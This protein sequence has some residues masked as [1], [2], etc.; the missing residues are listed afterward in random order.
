M[1]AIADLGITVSVPSNWHGEILRLHDGVSDSGPILHVAN[2]P[3][4]LGDTSGYATQT[5]Q[6]M[7]VTD[8]ILCVLNLPS[9]PHLLRADGVE[10]VGHSRRWS[11]AG[12]SETPFNAVNTSQSSL[13]KAIRVG[14]RVFDVIAFFGT[15]SPEPTLRKEVDAILGT[16]RADP[17]PPRPGSRIE[18]Y[19]NTAS[20]LQIEKE[21]ERELW[22]RDSQYATSEEREEHAKAFPNG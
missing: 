6:T 18:Q 20:A 11:L 4:I 13:R 9:L 17:A 1:A 15:P 7:R 21:V 5:R 12:A 10:Q 2:T 3:L 19:F 8:A 16:V 14:E 22:E